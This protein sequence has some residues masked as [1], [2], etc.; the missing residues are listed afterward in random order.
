MTAPRKS[1]NQAGT[2]LLFWLGLGFVAFGVFLNWAIRTAPEG[3]PS[4]LYS[5]TPSQRLARMVPQDIAT[6]ITL[7]FAWLCG[8]FGLLL[9]CGAFWDVIRRFSEKRR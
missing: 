2:A 1:S 7:A 9:L 6:Q 4:E 5:A 8:I 3:R